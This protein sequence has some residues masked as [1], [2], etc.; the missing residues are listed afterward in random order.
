MPEDEGPDGPGDITDAIGRQRRHD[1]DCR[2]PRWEEYLG[3]DQ[4]SRCGVNE[5]VMVPQRRP[6]PAARRRLLRLVRPFWLVFGRLCHLGLLRF[7]CLIA[8][9]GRSSSNG[10]QKIYTMEPRSSCGANTDGCTCRYQVDPARLTKPIY[11]LGERSLYLPGSL[12][13]GWL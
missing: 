12:A 6:D 2:G 8:L 7:F 13:T 9:V 10:L 3:K 5:E 4:G 11:R 1:C